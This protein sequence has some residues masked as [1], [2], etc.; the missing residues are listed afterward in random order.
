MSLMASG[1]CNVLSLE[2][3]RNAEAPI[4]EVFLFSSTEMRDVQPLKALSGISR[5]PPRAAWAIEVHSAN[6][7]PPRNVKEAG[8]FTSFRST[9]PKN[10]CPP[11]LCSLSAKGISVRDAQPKNAV[12][13]I[14]LSSGMSDTLQSAWQ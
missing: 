6:A 9:Q 12:S 4:D 14:V 11:M 13:D 5:R 7:A 2:Q 8:S 3:S 1:I 10:A